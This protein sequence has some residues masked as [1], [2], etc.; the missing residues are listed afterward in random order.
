VTA[1]EKARVEWLRSLPSIIAQVTN[2]WSLTVGSPFRSIDE[3]CSWV[4]PATDQNGADAV[5]KVNLPHFEEEHEIQGLRFWDGEPTVRLLAADDELHA[6]LLERCVPGGSLRE[7]PEAEQD[8]VIAGLLRRMW[9]GPYAAH[10][11]RSLETML[12]HWTT[13]SE[14]GIAHADDPGLVREG[15]E[16]FHSLSLTATQRFLLA[17]DLHAG[18]ILRSGREP[19]LVIDP[20]P[21]VGDPAYDATQHL[22]NCTDR[23]LT[24]PDRTIKTF[25]DLLEV[26]AERVGLWIFARAAVASV[27]VDGSE[28]K[29]SMQIARALNATHPLK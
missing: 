5:L 7:I 11:F 4:A 28:A 21:F 25:A 10:P 26:N 27:A 14:D 29:R 13:E 12:A 1:L 20:K 3:G 17:T 15:I 23:L 22:L 2:R 16:L 24:Q 8:M 18:N 6:M 19:W 9:R